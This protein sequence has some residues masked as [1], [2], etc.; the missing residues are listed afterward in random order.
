MLLDHHF[1]G[2]F[3]QQDKVNECAAHVHRH[4]VPMRHAGLPF[5]RHISNL[6]Q[7][8]AGASSPPRPDGTLAL[9]YFDQGTHIQLVGVEVAFHLRIDKDAD[10]LV[11]MYTGIL[12]ESAVH[13]E[14]IWFHS[15]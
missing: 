14:S 3:I 1:A 10:E 13:N 11:G 2:G 5:S 6:D 4:T 12:G 15:A 9:P 7:A 8:G